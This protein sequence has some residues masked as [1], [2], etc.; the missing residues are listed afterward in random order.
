ML[1]AKEPLITVY[2]WRVR[3]DADR[4]ISGVTDDQG[5]ALGDMLG[6]FA[7]LPGM[8]LRAD[9]RIVGVNPR[10][11]AVQYRRTRT[12]VLAQR[13]PTHPTMAPSTLPELVG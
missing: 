7:E 1:S 3:S 10:E 13:S 9:L 11:V 5:K 12:L 4:E 8:P 2:A 6:A